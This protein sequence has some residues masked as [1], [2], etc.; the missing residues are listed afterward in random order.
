MLVRFR[1]Q[2]SGEDLEVPADLVGLMVAM[3]P[4]EDSDHV[5]HVAN[6]S[7]DRDGWFIESHPKLDPVATTTDGVFIAGACQAPKDVP[8]AVAQARAAVARIL[9]KIS[10]GEIAVD[11][12]YSEVDERLCAGCRKCSS[13]C[14]YTAI[15]FDE[16]KKRSVIVSAACK[17]C[18][19]CSAGC[20]CGAIQTRHFNDQQ[21]YAQIEAVL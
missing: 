8:E 11:G 4:R 20:P 9:A 13:L 10:R 14:P 17:A 19:C 18:G 15:T 7:R 2:L 3:Q 5:A 16:V 12:V 1:E 6:I 21:L